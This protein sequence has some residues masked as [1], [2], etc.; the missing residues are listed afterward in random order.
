MEQWLSRPGFRP[1]PLDGSCPPYSFYLT[2]VGIA[3]GNQR[4]PLCSLGRTEWK[5]LYSCRQRSAHSQQC[6]I[7]GIGCTPAFRQ[8]GCLSLYGITLKD[9][10]GFFWP[11]CSKDMGTC[12]NQAIIRHNKTGSDTP[13]AYN[14]YNAIE[15]VHIIDLRLSCLHVGESEEHALLHLTNQPLLS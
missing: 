2:R 1:V 12:D 7:L 13:V 11:G 4:V 3:E 6:D 8:H 5:R 15:H 10:E 9:D 14:T